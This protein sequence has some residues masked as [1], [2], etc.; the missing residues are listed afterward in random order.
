MGGWRVV[1]AVLAAVRNVIWEEVREESL[2]KY[3]MRE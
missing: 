2:G 3:Q 1:S